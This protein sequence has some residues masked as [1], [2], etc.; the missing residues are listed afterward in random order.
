MVFN[1][2]NLITEN[3]LNTNN[4][5]MNSSIEESY[6]ATTLGFVTE[7]MREYRTYNKELYKSILESGEDYEVITESFSDFFTKIKELIEK[8]LKFIKSL[9]DRFIATL[10][11]FV[12]SEKYLIKHKADFGKFNTERHGFTFEGYDYTFVDNIPSIEAAAAFNKD[13]VGLDFDGIMSLKDTDKITAKIAAQHG[14][15][16]RELATDRYDVFRQEVISADAPIEA[17]DFAKELFMVFRNGDDVKEE[18]EITNSRVIES[19]ARLQNHKQFQTSVKKTKDKIEREY[20]AVKKSVENMIYRNKDKDVN[21]LLSVEIRGEY[22]GSSTPILLSSEAMTKVDLFIKTKIK[23]INEL[24]SIHALAFSYKL[25]AISECYKQD[26]AILYRALNKIQKDLKLECVISEGIL[27]N[28]KS[29]K[30][31]KKYK[32][33]LNY[34]NSLKEEGV[35][36]NEFKSKYLPKMIQLSETIQK[37]I[38]S[39]TDNSKFNGNCEIYLPM[40]HKEDYKEIKEDLTDFSILSDDK[41]YIMK[42]MIVVDWSFDNDSDLIRYRNEVF[43]IADGVTMREDSFKI[44]TNINSLSIMCEE[45]IYDPKLI[46]KKIKNIENKL[47]S[48][49]K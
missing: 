36:I 3:A 32:S 33:K 1:F 2:N 45:W 13:F 47:K 28:I 5:L 8:F 39:H 26:K 18:L 12:S 49:D 44:I 9:F 46:D 25:D 15:L 42:K 16:N 31:I 35:S 14:A 43:A 38:K 22:D 10:N 48:I 4:V 24:S 30:E 34:L 19:L 6:F 20:N 41:D 21:K 29:K 37:K 17:A 11:R 27:D 40:M 23:E 7:S